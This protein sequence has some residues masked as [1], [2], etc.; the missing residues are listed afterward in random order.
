[1]DSRDLDGRTVVDAVR[2]QD[3]KPRHK[4]KATKL[5]N[6]FKENFNVFIKMHHGVEAEMFLGNRGTLRKL[7]RNS[8]A[9]G[10]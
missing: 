2:S 8:K 9:N 10:L 5:R 1:M 6:Q 4:K 7:R 3:A